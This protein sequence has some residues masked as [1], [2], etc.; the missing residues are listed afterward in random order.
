LLASWRLV[1]WWP[2]DDRQDVDAVAGEDG[3]V[4]V[5]L[6]EAGGGDVVGYNVPVAVDTEGSGID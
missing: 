2:R 3:D 6:E 5:V 4:R 1:L